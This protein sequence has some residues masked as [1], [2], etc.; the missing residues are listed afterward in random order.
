MN[1]FRMTQNPQAPLKATGWVK[2]P[3]A[4]S[5][6]AWRSLALTTAQIQAMK[7]ADETLLRYA[8]G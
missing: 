1:S 3:F 8:I 6:A 2:V 7:D 4:R 5:R